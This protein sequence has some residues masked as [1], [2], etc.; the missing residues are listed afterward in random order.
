[1]MRFRDAFKDVPF[2]SKNSLE[3]RKLIKTYLSLTLVDVKME[4]L[5]QESYCVYYDLISIRDDVSS[6]TKKEYLAALKKRFKQ[7][8][9]PPL[10]NVADLEIQMDNKIA[11][12]TPE[13]I[14]IEKEE[15]NIVTEQDKKR[16][17]QTIII[18][19]T[20]L[21]QIN[22]FL[23]VISKE[24]RNVWQSWLEFNIYN[25]GDIVQEDGSIKKRRIKDFLNFLY[26]QK[27]IKKSRTAVYNLL[28]RGVIEYQKKCQVR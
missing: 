28:N 13:D 14:Y 17:I 15:E 23:E 5:I 9:M 27:G 6:I 1:M 18:F 11:E 26:E 24:K 21:V 22:T 25:T 3:I 2:L 20:F 12:T 4:D 19:F 7:L 8:R 16:E 10:F